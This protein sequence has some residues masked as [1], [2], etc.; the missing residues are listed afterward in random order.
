MKEDETREKKEKEKRKENKEYFSQSQW[1][2]PCIELQ[3][4]YCRTRT[5]TVPAF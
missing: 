3:T 1:S 4:A 2:D 5:K